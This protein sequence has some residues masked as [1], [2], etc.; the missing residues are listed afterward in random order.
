MPRPQFCLDRRHSG[1]RSSRSRILRVARFTTEAPGACRADQRDADKPAR[2][3]CLRV[4]DQLGSHSVVVER[5]RP[6][7]VT[8]VISYVLP[9]GGNRTVLKVIDEITTLLDPAAGVRLRGAWIECR[10]ATPTLKSSS[11]RGW[12]T[13]CYKGQRNDRSPRV[14]P[15]ACRARR[16]GR[17]RA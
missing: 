14:V 16:S 12:R 4:A 10:Q 3:I 5:P 17:V 2:W 9:G 7:T 1:Q 15:G 11:R 13:D 6:T 8:S